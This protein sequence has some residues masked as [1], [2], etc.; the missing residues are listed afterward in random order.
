MESLMQIW[1][2][3]FCLFSPDFRT[4]LFIP[5][6]WEI[7][8]R[9]LGKNYFSPDGPGRLIN[10]NTCFLLQMWYVLLF[11]FPLSFYSI[12]SL[13]GTPFRNMLSFPALFFMS[14]CFCFCFL[15]RATSTPWVKKR[16]IFLLRRCSP[17]PSIHFSI[18]KDSL[19]LDI[20]PC[21]YGPRYPRT[22]NC[23]FLELQT[24]ELLCLSI[25]LSHFPYCIFLDG[26]L[27]VVFF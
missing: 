17:H 15:W 19:P 9:F 12:L 26:C 8:P 7:W 18:F 13:S 25:F 4:F 3:S 10:L 2:S 5:L 20:F 23:V 1:F 22:L 14:Q 6:Y 11:I 16:Y 24:L 27:N 21:S